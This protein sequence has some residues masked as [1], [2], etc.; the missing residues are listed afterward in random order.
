[1]ISPSI[2]IPIHSSQIMSLSRAS[3]IL[4]QAASVRMLSPTSVTST[5][6]VRSYGGKAKKDQNF[7][8]RHALNVIGLPVVAFLLFV[9]LPTF[10]TDEIHSIDWYDEQYVKE[11][12]AKEAAKAAARAAAAAGN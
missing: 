7:I 10:R 6:I 8:Q 1:M 4:R 9:V 12:K 5:T 3:V 2:L 11:T